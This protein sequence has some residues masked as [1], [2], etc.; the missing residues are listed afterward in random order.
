MKTMDCET[1]GMLIDTDEPIDLID[2]RPKGEFAAM[3]IPGARSIP[4]RELSQRHLFRK[5]SPAAERVYVISDDRGSASLAAGILRASNDVDAV[6][7][8]GGMRA[9]IKQGLPLRQAGF[10]PKIPNYLRTAA[11]I[12]AVVC[13]GFALRHSLLAAVGLLAGAALLLKARMLEKAV[14]ESGDQIPAT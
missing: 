2:V 12:L 6:V 13:I 5:I 11:A 9:W 1:L 8:D 10:G 4:L 7:I 14:N 3:H